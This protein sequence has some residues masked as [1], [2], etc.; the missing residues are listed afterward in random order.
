MQERTSYIDEATFDEFKKQ[1]SI[2]QTNAASS[3]NAQIIISQ[4]REEVRYHNEHKS[5]HPTLQYL[6]KRQTPLHICA[7]NGDFNLCN[8]LLKGGAN[9]CFTNNSGQTALHSLL[10]HDSSNRKAPQE[11]VYKLFI[12]SNKNIIFEKDNSGLSPLQIIN[13]KDF[14]E[15]SNST[16]P[17]RQYFANIA[18]ILFSRDGDK[19]LLDLKDFQI[20]HFIVRYADSAHCKKFT[21]CL[22]SIQYIDPDT[23]QNYVNLP[24]PATGRNVLHIAA[25]NSLDDRFDSL[26]WLTANLFH[27]DKEGNTPKNIIV[28]NHL[29]CTN[30]QL[31]ILSTVNKIELE[32]SKMINKM[33]GTKAPSPD[34]ELPNTELNGSFANKSTSACL[35]AAF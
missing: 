24:D 25:K 16:N 20:L 29:K 2:L 9:P 18:C 33:N 3:E 28:R 4:I 11:Q 32:L 17:V 30:G 19:Q 8:A 12:E 34:T 1:F 35:Q 21:D 10:K 7:E 27:R 26:I 23:I 5:P 6:K 22:K 15:R 13:S 14:S 31:K